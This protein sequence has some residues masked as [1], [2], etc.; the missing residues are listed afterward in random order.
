MQSVAEE[1]MA[2]TKPTR[3]VLTFGQCT[4]WNGFHD[5]TL[6]IWTQKDFRSVKAGESDSIIVRLDYDDWCSLQAMNKRLCFTEK[7]E[8]P[9]YRENRR[10]YTILERLFCYDPNKYI[11]LFK[12]GDK[13]DLKR[14]NVTC[15]PA[16]H[17]E[18]I[19]TRNVVEYI[20]GHT[21]TIG[22]QSGVMK[23]PIWR[24]VEG[25]TEYLLMYCEKDTICRLC[26]ESYKRVL[27]FETSQNDGKKLSFFKNANGYILS[28][29]GSSGLY[30]HQIIAGCYGNGRGTQN[31]SVDHIDR[32]PLNNTV[33]NLRIATREEQQQ[34]TRGQLEGTKKAR[35]SDAR[36]LPDGITE[37]IVPPYVTYAE[38]P[39]GTNGK[40][41]NYF[42]IANHP[43]QHQSGIIYTSK[44]AKVSI[45]EKLEE[46]KRIVAQLDQREITNVAEVKPKQEAE[47]GYTMPPYFHPTTQHGK[48]AVCF[49]RRYDDG[50]RRVGIKVTIKEGETAQQAVQRIME[51]VD[52]ETGEKKTK[53][54]S[55]TS[56]GST[57][58]KGFSVC[59]EK[60]SGKKYLS[61]QRNVKGK[62]YVGRTFVGEGEAVAD[63]LVRLKDTIRKRYELDGDDDSVIS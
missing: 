14:H 39:Y 51:Q 13:H 10:D 5:W 28:H 19:N 29:I 42:C 11:Y 26:P 52:V 46:A 53:P 18:L 36:P 25:D 2:A 59:T 62:R 33:A 23:N 21:K 41:R 43:N 49:E 63:V 54:V 1:T 12:N 50:R 56:D 24:V 4:G 17:N 16:L 45:A 20:P 40:T 7:H 32:D 57:L 30:I 47:P 60:S 38:S 27:A 22:Q 31:I 37:E 48:P 44:S 35:R 58:P 61:F 8:Y 9:Y 3:Y 15:C 55:T 6:T 34:N